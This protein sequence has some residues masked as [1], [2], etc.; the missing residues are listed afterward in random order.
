M[1]LSGYFVAPAGHISLNSSLHAGH[2]TS[3]LKTNSRTDWH[4]R[5]TIE[6]G[7]GGDSQKLSFA[8]PSHKYLDKSIMTRHRNPLPLRLDS[9]RSCVPYRDATS[10]RVPSERSHQSG[11]G[12]E[13]AV[14]APV[15]HKRLLAPLHILRVSGSRVWTNFGRL[16]SSGSP[17]ALCRPAVRVPWDLQTNATT[18]QATNRQTGSH[19]EYGWNPGNA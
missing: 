3:E 11:C 19:R 1:A 4:R 16:T 18:H 6:I 14:C 13:A 5:K 2:G 9:I 8:K 10:P 12:A 7:S 15:A 17:R